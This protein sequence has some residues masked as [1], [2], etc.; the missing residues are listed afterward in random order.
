MN[1]FKHEVINANALVGDIDLK[2]VY[3]IQTTHNN[4]DMNKLTNESLSHPIIPNININAKM[5]LW[6][7]LKSIILNGQ[8]IAKVF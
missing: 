2:L 1:L 6:S 5:Q 4:L 3:H 8:I 7:I